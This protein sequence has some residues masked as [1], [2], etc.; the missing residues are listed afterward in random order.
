MSVRMVIVGY[1][2]AFG[3]GHH[4]AEWICAG[5]WSWLSPRADPGAPQA[6]GETEVPTYESIEQ[7]L[8][9]DNVDMVALI[10]LHDLHAPWPCRR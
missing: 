5:G 10:S 2:S 9:D 3:M 6:A 8:A 4:H 7:V 1:G